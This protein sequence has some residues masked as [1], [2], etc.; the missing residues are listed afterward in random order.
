MNIQFLNHDTLTDIITFNLSEKPAQL[1]GE[2]YISTD[3]V[4]ENA[5]WHAASF[6]KEL[7]RVIFHGALHLCGLKDKTAS[8]KTE[9]R[10]AEDSSLAGWEKFLALAP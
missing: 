4:Q 9:M 7:H 3:R 8:Q 6:S 5:Q 10:Q 1:Q 2:I